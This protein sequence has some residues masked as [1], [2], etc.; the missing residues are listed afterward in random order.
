MR[1]IVCSTVDSG[2]TQITGWDM[3]SWTWVL[4]DAFPFRIHLASVIALGDDADKFFSLH[5]QQ[6]SDPLWAI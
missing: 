3:I 6:R 2:L 5:H 4:R 1:A